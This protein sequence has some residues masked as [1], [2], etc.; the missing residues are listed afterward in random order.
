MPRPIK[1]KQISEIPK[2][3][4]FSSDN[5]NVQD[6]VILSIEEYEVIRNCD[7]D[8]LDQENCAKL[9]KTS[10]TT[11]QRI[12][13]NA[14]RKIAEALVLGKTIEIAVDTS[15]HQFCAT[16]PATPLNKYRLAIGIDHGVVAE[17][18]SQCAEYLVIDIDQQQVVNQQLIIDTS[19]ERFHRASFLQQHDI[20]ILMVKSLAKGA[21][22][23]LLSMNI[24]C[25]GTN[26]Q[27]PTKALTN[28]LQSKAVDINVR[29]G[30]CLG[31]KH[32]L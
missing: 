11:I 3:R 17:H 16:L 32:E 2:C 9:M 23:R 14:R 18:L 24:Q 26:D 4:R 15:P 1:V 21:Y 10:R 31:A 20:D 7:Y 22:N 12:Y 8:R 28:Y 5:N 25:V 30:H 13:A 19:T 6:S 27:D 29:S